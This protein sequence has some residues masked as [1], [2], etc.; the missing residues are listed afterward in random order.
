MPR[1]TNPP[2]ERKG[3]PPRKTGGR[4]LE[5]VPDPEPEEEL[6]PDEA[7][8]EIEQLQDDL[9]QA[10]IDL[11]DRVAEEVEKTAGKR[12]RR[13]G[14]RR[15]DP[16][17][18]TEE[19]DEEGSFVARPDE[20]PTD[21]A[22]E[23]ESAEEAPA[24]AKETKPKPKRRPRVNVVAPATTNVK[25]FEP[26][27]S[28]LQPL[29]QKHEYLRVVLYGDGGAGKST[30]MASLANRGVI[31][32]VDPENSVRKKALA[33]HGV[34]VDN[35]LMWPD[36]TY[37]GMEQLYVTVKAKLEEEPGSIYAV[38][39]DTVTALASFWLEEDVEASMRRPDMQRKH[40]TRTQFDVFQDDYGTLTQQIQA[41]ITRKLYQLPCHVVIT[42]HARRG[43]N[44]DG[45]VRV[46]PALSPAASQSLFTYSDWV[47]R[48]T[49]TEKNGKVKR[50]LDTGARGNIEA[51]ER[52]GI[53]EEQMSHH[54][55][56]ELVELW[57]ESDSDG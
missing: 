43:E 5:A 23:P 26:D 56:E 51:K 54:S 45:L 35:I 16:A 25:M 53:F 41:L 49:L 36:W 15:T 44:E 4:K 39:I 42:A 33:R 24:E 37:D 10:D 38:V 7:L 27:F 50:G 21:A 13:G 3:R 1:L 57:E 14:T 29:T 31:V 8:A 52:F 19:E 9:T 2:G 32:V 12:K 28:R 48:M 55:L 34:N 46:G 20:D 6:F 17:A 47:F 22:P 11:L 18:T 40:P 30:S